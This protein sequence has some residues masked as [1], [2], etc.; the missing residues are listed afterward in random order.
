MLV[1]EL[2]YPHH[3]LVGLRHLPVNSLVWFHSLVAIRLLT[4]A[5]L[6]IVPL[7]Q[8]PSQRSVLA[9]MLFSGTFLADRRTLH[10]TSSVG[11]PGNVVCMPVEE[12]VTRLHVMVLLD[13]SRVQDPLVGKL[14]V[15]R[16]EIVG[17][18][19][20]RHVTLLPYAQT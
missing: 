14:V 16:E 19:A 11:R 6:E 9:D 13:L 18:R 15:H 10:V 8:C 1:G 12:L 4:A 5:T 2:Q 7:V 17:I 20:L 3:C